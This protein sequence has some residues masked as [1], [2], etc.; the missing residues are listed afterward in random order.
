MNDNGDYCTIYFLTFGGKQLEISTKQGKGAGKKSKRRMGLELKLLTAEL[1][2]PLL[3]AV[4]L[5]LY[6][7]LDG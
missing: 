7:W 3:M 2:H 5:N 4:L 6:C 1:L